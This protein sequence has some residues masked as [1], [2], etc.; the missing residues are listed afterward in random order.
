MATVSVPLSISEFQL[1]LRLRQ[2][3]KENAGAG[4]RVELE[5]HATKIQIVDL[6]PLRCE[7]FA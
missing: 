2:L 3:R 6:R 4:M 5:V 7:V 1:L